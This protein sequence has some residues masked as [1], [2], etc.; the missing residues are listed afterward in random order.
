MTKKFTKHVNC[1]IPYQMATITIVQN[2]IFFALQQYGLH[3]KRKV[4]ENKWFETSLA[5]QPPSQASKLCQHFFNSRIDFSSMN[6]QKALTFGFPV[7][8]STLF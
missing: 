8:S 2:R 6:E 1:Q 5:L 7:H 3:L 4:E